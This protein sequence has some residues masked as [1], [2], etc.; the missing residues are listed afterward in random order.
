MSI[1]SKIIK[2]ATK[3]PRIETYDSFLFIGP[4]PD[5]IEIGAG[6]VGVLIPPFA[7]NDKHLDSSDFS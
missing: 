2:I 7:I 6:S 1:I 5:D 4:H 3:T